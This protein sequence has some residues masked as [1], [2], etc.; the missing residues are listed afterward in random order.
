MYRTNKIRNLF[1]TSH[2]KENWK[3]TSHSQKGFA[4]KNC[5]PHSV[6]V[7]IVVTVILLLISVRCAGVWEKRC[8]SRVGRSAT[9]PIGRPTLTDSQC[10]WAFRSRPPV[11]YRFFQGIL[12]KSRVS[13]QDSSDSPLLTTE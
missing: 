6:H 13:L 1:L 2:E 9:F 4:C 10:A 8:S 12:V 7:L 3:D 11:Y 5:N